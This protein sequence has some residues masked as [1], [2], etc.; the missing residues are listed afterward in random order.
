MSAKY[1]FKTNGYDVEVFNR[2][3][4]IKTIDENI[5]DKDVAMLIVEQCEQ[6]AITFL[7]QGRWVGIPYI[8]NVRVPKIKQITNNPEQKA[9]L[10]EARA[11]LSKERYIM[12]KKRVN[13]DNAVRVKNERFFNYMVSIAISKHRSLYKQYFKERG[14]TYAKLKMFFS[15]Q[16]NPFIYDYEDEI[17]CRYFTND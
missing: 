17:G 4:I 8:G 10:E 1:K 3:D 14:E 15:Q 9:L 5:L 16:I 6:D 2:A 7:N 13:I 12:F 11:N